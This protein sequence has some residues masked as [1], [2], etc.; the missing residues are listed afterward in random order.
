MVSSNWERR[1]PVDSS[2]ANAAAVNL[3]A[4]DYRGYCRAMWPSY[5]GNLRLKIENF[6]E[7]TTIVEQAQ[8][9]SHEARPIRSGK[10]L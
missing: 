2:G 6:V 9:G 7:V 4:N 10:V 3:Q 5:C 8:L 1:G